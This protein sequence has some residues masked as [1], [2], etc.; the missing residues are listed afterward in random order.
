VGESAD[1]GA[2]DRGYGNY[3]MTEMNVGDVFQMSG[4]T[5]PSILTDKWWRVEA[6][7]PDGAIHLSPPH[8]DAEMTQVYHPVDPWTRK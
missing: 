3:Q 2:S 4:R 7:D 5:V 8:L 6:V 1:G